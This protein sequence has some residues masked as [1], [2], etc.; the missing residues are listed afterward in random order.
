M[1]TDPDTI[2][3]EAEDAMQR[4]VDYLNSELRG[5]RAGRA[6]TAMVEY[7]KVDCY[8]SQSDLKSMAA[9]SVPEPTQILIKPF[10]PST[11]SAIKQ[12]I[13]QA[14]LGVNPMVEDKAIRIMLPMMS[15][16]RREQ[17]VAQAKKAGEEQKVVMRNARRDAN[18]AADALSKSTTNPVSEDDVKQLHQEIQELL[19][20][21]EAKIDDSVA[22]KSAEIREI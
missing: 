18:K 14:Q 10:D 16:E 3:L 19:K 11:L 2:L 8:G 4:A 20:K 15:A 12:G 1:S 5:L 22:K 21:Y 6:S 7:V 13:E 9:I 17:L